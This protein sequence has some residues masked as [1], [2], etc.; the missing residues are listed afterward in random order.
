MKA[1]G[2]TA[3]DVVQLDV[4]DL[5]ATALGIALNRTAETAA[6]SEATL[7]KLLQEL[8][9]E[10]A[11]D[12][13]GFDADDIDELLASIE[14]DLGDG[15]PEED[16]VP[17]PPPVATTRRMSRGRAISDRGRGAPMPVRWYGVV[18]PRPAERP[19]T[20]CA[21]PSSDPVRRPR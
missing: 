7:A 2:W 10:D 4:D 8:Q 6:W 20:S 16:A 14:G 12:G 21:R 15:D 11:L 5:T 3:C 13:V 19:L 17:E 9:A 18:A 1:L